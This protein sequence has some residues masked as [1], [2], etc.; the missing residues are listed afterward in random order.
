[1]EKGRIFA[2]QG[3]PFTNRFW[4]ICLA[5]ASSVSLAATDFRAVKKRHLSTIGR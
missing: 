1:M 5:D 3:V 4:R 2:W